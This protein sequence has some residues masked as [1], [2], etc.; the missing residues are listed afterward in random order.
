MFIVQCKKSLQKRS[1][2]QACCQNINDSMRKHALD[3]C[4]AFLFSS[5]LAG[6]VLV[7]TTTYAG[8]VLFMI[9]KRRDLLAKLAI[10]RGKLVL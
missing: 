5:N 2:K 3:V 1:L 6:F 10:S 9:K 7:A 4:H 8:N